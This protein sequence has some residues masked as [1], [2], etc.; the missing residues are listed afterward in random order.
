MTA[1]SFGK[2]KTAPS[3]SASSKFPAK[4]APVTRPVVVA[5][6]SSPERNASPV[7][8]NQQTAA[9]SAVGQNERRRK[10]GWA[11]ESILPNLQEDKHEDLATFLGPNADKFLKI[12][13]M[14]DKPRSKLNWAA[15]FL[16][17]VWFFYRKM[18]LIGALFVVLPIVLGYLIPV[19]GVATSAVAGHLGNGL[20]LR[21]AIRRI[22]KADELGLHGEE[23]IAY[24][25]RAGGVSW[26]AGVIAGLFFAG[27]IALVL[28][29]HAHGSR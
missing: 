24:L 7:A 13:E 22:K 5:A 26:P 19:G 11:F 20:Y 6:S 21:D 12:Y 10:A 1:Q 27:I 9:A 29:S 17:F 4:A 28:L 25:K 15:F 3:G 16:G 23:R 8:V 2:R 18:Y 14:R